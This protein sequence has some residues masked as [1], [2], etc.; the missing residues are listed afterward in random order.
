MHSNTKG[1]DG[2]RAN[3]DETARLAPAAVRCLV[4]VFDSMVSLALVGLCD[5][6]CRHYL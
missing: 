2:G 6:A 4:Y 1:R 3:E 5:A